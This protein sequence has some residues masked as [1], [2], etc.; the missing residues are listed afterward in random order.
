VFAEKLLFEQLKEHRFNGSEVLICDLQLIK[1]TIQDIL[2]EIDGDKDDKIAKVSEVIKVINFILVSDNC[3][4][5]IA[6][7]IRNN[8]LGFENGKN[9]R[10]L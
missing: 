6:Y 5:H 2:C 8:T 1:T 3:N 7:F 9:S 10:I 4:N